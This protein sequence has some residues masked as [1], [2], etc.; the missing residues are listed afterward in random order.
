[1][2]DSLAVQAEKALKA[3]VV[4][5]NQECIDASDASTEAQKERCEDGVAAH[6]H[7]VTENSDNAIE[8]VLNFL[9]SK[10]S[11]FSRK[12]NPIFRVEK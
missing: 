7:A 10:F 8:T 5:L 4:E 2:A 6:L 3:K 9:K 1:M 12:G 11:G